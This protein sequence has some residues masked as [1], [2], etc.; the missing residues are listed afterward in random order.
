MIRRIK[1]YPEF[2]FWGLAAQLAAVARAPREACWPYIPGCTAV[3]TP[4]VS[5]TA[6]G[7]WRY[8]SGT[9]LPPRFRKTEM[10]RKGIA[11]VSLW[12]VSAANM[13]DATPAR[14]AQAHRVPPAAALGARDPLFTQSCKEKAFF[15]FLS[16][17]LR[18]ASAL[19]VCQRAQ[20]AAGPAGELCPA[21]SPRCP[22]AAPV[23][24]LGLQA[25][26]AALL[27]P[28][29]PSASRASLGCYSVIG[30]ISPVPD[31]DE[32]HLG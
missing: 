24:F 30:T 2:Y 17:C 23:P 10:R 27:T 9:Q 7:T 29:C 8:L 19:P 6:P 22:A 13:S 20:K 14:A 18:P 3:C 21:P 5:E 28:S 31:T 16:P 12:A 4:V 15:L 1:L 11:P 26:Q 32:L 25:E